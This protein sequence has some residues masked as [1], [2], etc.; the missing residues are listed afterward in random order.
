MTKAR[1]NS[2]YTGLAADITAAGAGKLLRITRYTS[3][4]GT[5]TKP[6]D[7]VSVLIK[8]VAGGGGGGGG[9]ASGHINFLII[10]KLYHVPINYYCP[11]QYYW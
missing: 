11:K 8:T 9:S 6:S 2:D 4:S 3:G 1:E 5:W 7:T 10:D